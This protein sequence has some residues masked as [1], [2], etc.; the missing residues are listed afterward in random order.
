[1]VSARN[2]T[3]GDVLSLTYTHEVKVAEDNLK[4]LFEA[5]L[6]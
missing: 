6:T 5:I 4:E 2:T 3:K 1:M